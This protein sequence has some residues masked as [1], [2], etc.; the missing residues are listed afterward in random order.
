MQAKLSILIMTFKPVHIAFWSGSNPTT[1][2]QTW[3]HAA[4]RV[5]GG[6]DKGTGEGLSGDLGLEIWKMIAALTTHLVRVLEEVLHNVDIQNAPFLHVQACSEH[7]P[8]QSKMVWPSISGFRNGLGD[9]TPTF[10]LSFISTGFWS[11]L[12]Y[13]MLF[14]S[15]SI[16]GT[17]VSF[18]GVQ[19]FLT[20]MDTKGLKMAS[21][22]SKSIIL[23]PGYFK[24]LSWRENSWQRHAN[25]SPCLCDMTILDCHV[26][27]P[28]STC[29][30]CT[31]KWRC[32]ATASQWT[33][34]NHHNHHNHHEPL[35]TFINQ[36]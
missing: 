15:F 16:V 23:D 34:S 19:C 18:F 21:S 28:K 4:F 9:Q 22:N 24:F 13:I 33:L 6:R 35:W 20:A 25:R 5:V 14:V 26:G 17:R 12:Y 29:P 8:Q 3:P 10:F 30:A 11:Q 27:L 32:A 7:R 2:G 36:F 1:A 31:T